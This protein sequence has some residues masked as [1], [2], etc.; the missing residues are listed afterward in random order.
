MV[1][2]PLV[3]VLRLERQD[4]PLD[5]GVEVGQE[6]DQLVGQREIHESS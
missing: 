3:V 6:P 1:E 4:L 2:E 5:E